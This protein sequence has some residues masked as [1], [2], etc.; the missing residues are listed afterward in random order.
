MQQ[1][2]GGRGFSLIQDSGA[3]T[4]SCGYCD[5]YGSATHGMHAYRLTVYDYQELLDQGWRRSGKFLYK[6]DNKETC[7]RQYTIRLD[8]TQNQPSKAHKRLLRRWEQFLA[9][10][11]Q[12]G[13]S[14]AEGDLHMADAAQQLQQQAGNSSSGSSQRGPKRTRQGN[15]AVSSATA[16]D[17]VAGAASDKQQQQQPGIAAEFIQEEFDLYCKYQMQQHNDSP[18]ELTPSRYR[19][20]LV[21]TPL[22]PVPPPA[23]AAAAAAPPPA[24]AAA[25]AADGAAAAAAVPACGY[26]SF[27]Q[28]YRLDGKLVAVGV[29]DVLPRCLSSKYF[30]WDPDYAWLSLGRYGALREIDWVA[31]A[32]AAG[33][34]ELRY[35]YLGYY[36]H[37]CPKMAY[38]AEYAPSELLCPQRQVWVGLDATVR[39]ALDAAPYVVLSDLPGVRLAPN[40]SVPRQ[41][42]AAAEA[43]A[44]AAAQDAAAAAAGVGMPQHLGLQAQLAA[45]QR[46]RLDAQLLLLL[47]QPVRWGALRE[48]GMLDGEQV[49]ELEERLAAWLAVVG[50][51]AAHLL[52]ATPSD[53]LSVA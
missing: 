29:V 41:L 44:T 7:C 25:G 28:Q 18:A 23:A 24:A 39:A 9:G 12:H 15:N 37:T 17:D 26:G 5:G 40:L 11:L 35:Y 3:Y 50:E 22:I 27:H 20:F 43:P 53:L 10:Q 16:A 48:S 49:G 32:H 1:Q 8:V 31:Q 34:S 47:K 46:Q 38:K 36:I 42:P 6:P 21:D 19:N 14:D 30:F 2:Q 51:T 13:V 52:Y 45:R 4:S 33:A